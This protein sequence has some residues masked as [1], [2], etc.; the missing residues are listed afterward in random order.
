MK[1]AV[2]YLL[3]LMIASNMLIEAKTWKQMLN[4]QLEKE[5]QQKKI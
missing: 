1:H 2:L 4:E 5:R 3:G